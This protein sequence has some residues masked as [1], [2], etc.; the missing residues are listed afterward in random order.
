[1]DKSLIGVLGLK[2]GLITKIAFSVFSF[3][4]LIHP[5]PQ[6]RWER[7]KSKRQIPGD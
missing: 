1:M 5:P 2:H 6:A 3:V 7:T 4:L